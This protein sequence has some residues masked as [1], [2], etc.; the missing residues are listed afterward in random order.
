MGESVAGGRYKVVWRNSQWVVRA[1]DSR[2]VKECDGTRAGHA[3]ASVWADRAND[4][5]R[6]IDQP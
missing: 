4:K 2:V 6:A 1:P 3:A 5:L